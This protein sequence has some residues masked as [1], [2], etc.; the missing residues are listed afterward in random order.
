MRMTVAELSRIQH[1]R[2]RAALH[3]P[4]RGTA[5][6]LLAVACFA[7]PFVSNTILAQGPLAQETAGSAD[8]NPTAEL[9]APVNPNGTPPGVGTGPSTASLEALLP[10]LEQLQR[11][12][13]AQQQRTAQQG[14]TPQPSS[15]QAELIDNTPMETPG[16]VTIPLS[17]L[18]PQVDVDP[19]SGK[20]SLHVRDASLRDVL[21]MIAQ[22]L[23]INIVV[24]TGVDGRISLTLEGVSLEHVLDAMLM[25]TGNTWT[26][27][28]GIIHVTSLQINSPLPASLQNRVVRVFE[29]DFASATDIDVVV[30]SILTPVG[31][32]QI[33]LTDAADNRR[34]RDAIIV[35]DIAHNLPRITQYIRQLDMPPRQVM[36][37]AYVLEVELSDTIRNGVNFDHPASFA[38]NSVGFE[39]TGFANAASPPA[40]F[41]E[42]NGKNLTGLIELLETTADA[43]MLAS[44]KVMAVNGQKARI[45]IGERL[46]YRVTTTTE[47]SSLESVEFI[48][49]GVVLDVTPRVTRDGRVMMQV[50]PEVSGGEID[51][52]TGLPSE[53]TTEVETNVLLESGRGI[54]IGGLIQE[55]DIDNQ[56]KVPGLGDLKWVGPLFQRRTQEKK[57]TEIIVVLLPHVLP[58]HCEREQ[59]QAV[60]VERATT[61]LLWGPLSSYPRPWEPRLHNAYDNPKRLHRHEF[62]MAR[63]DYQVNSDILDQAP[64]GSALIG[65]AESVRINQD[66]FNQDPINVDRILKTPREFAELP[67]QDARPK[68]A[69]RPAA[70]AGESI[71]GSLDR[72]ATHKPL[73]LPPLPKQQAER[74]FTPRHPNMRRLPPLPQRMARR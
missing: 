34:T 3:A 7:L 36:I 70:P 23:R 43:K 6:A 38:G 53:E 1:A 20:I 26:R 19:L 56:S 29:L 37:E 24:A 42:I 48:D 11:A 27:V 13:D 64:V 68:L 67:S 45:Q 73:R 25:T 72:P 5:V 12:Q 46:G 62:E 65:Q 21:T 50:K 28:N 15:S 52:A 54:V 33:L 47:T 74:E 59:Q 49:V 31:A 2:L 63:H 44:P 4:F 66:L 30:K 10:F 55:R 16:R 8:T 9:G 61:P 71:Y 60:E 58:Y 69:N 32:S 51:P 17:G 22:Q 41:V 18:A 39:T 57:R 35:E 40:F 14:V